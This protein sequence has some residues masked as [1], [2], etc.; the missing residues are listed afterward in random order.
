[1]T[2]R[3]RGYP[4]GM[5]QHDSSQHAGHQAQEGRPEAQRPGRGG[6]ER[7]GHP[8]S[9]VPEPGADGDTAMERADLANG[10]PAARDDSDD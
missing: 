4:T 6:P 3:S 8:M 9:R 10:E 5:T 7:D 1:M 2:A